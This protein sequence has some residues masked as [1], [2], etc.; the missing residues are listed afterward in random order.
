MQSIDLRRYSRNCADDQRRPDGV[1]R[2]ADTGRAR[3]R[4]GQHGATCHCNNCA[5]CYA[6]GLADTGGHHAA[7]HTLGDADERNISNIH[8]N[9]ARSK[10]TANKWV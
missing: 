2:A 10:R 8:G 6:I 1:R 9:R 7:R 5:I 4:T 3:N